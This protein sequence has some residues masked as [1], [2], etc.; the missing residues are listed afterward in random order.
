MHTLLIF[1]LLLCLAGCASVRAR[2]T[3]VLA[4]ELN[5]FAAMT[6]ADTVR[7]KNFLAKD[8]LYIHSNGLVENRE[9]HIRAI[10]SGKL[11]YLDMQRSNAQIRLCRKY[12]LVSGNVLVKGALND[13]P[14]D[15]SLLYTA[16]YKSN[17]RHWQLVRWQSTKK[18][19]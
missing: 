5:R 6:Q 1:S 4:T 17:K 19:D 13:K 10:A 7:L 3:A 12:A 9:Q 18:T 16:F 14:F 2:E 15:I 8:L 11:K